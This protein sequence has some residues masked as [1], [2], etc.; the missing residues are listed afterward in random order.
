MTIEQFENQ[1]REHLRRTPFLPFIVKLSDGRTIFVDEPAVS[2]GGGRAGFIGPDEYVE[3]FDCEQVERIE[4][5]SA[6]PTT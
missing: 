5:A 2:F 3:F 4:L 1:L 6:E